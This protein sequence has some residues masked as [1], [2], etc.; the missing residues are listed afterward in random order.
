MR[1]Q[2]LCTRL[3]VDLTADIALEL[4]YIKHLS[5]QILHTLIIPCAVRFLVTMAKAALTKMFFRVIACYVFA[6]AH[7]HVVIDVFRGLTVMSF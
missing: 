7:Q 1:T 2:Q 4:L 3:E 5:C 6:V